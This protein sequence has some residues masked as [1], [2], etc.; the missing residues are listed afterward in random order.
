[1]NQKVSHVTLAQVPEPDTSVYASTSSP[2]AAASEQFADMQV[3]TLSGPLRSSNPVPVPTSPRPTRETPRYACVAQSGKAVPL[4]TMVQLL[5]PRTI[6]ACSKIIAQLDEERFL[7]RSIAWNYWGAGLHV[8]DILALEPEVYSTLPQLLLIQEME[9]MSRQMAHDRNYICEL[10][11]FDHSISEMAS[12]AREVFALV[13]TDPYRLA[14]RAALLRLKVRDGD[15]AWSQG[16]ASHMFNVDDHDLAVR[17][18]LRRIGHVANATLK[19]E[20]TV[21][22]EIVHVASYTPGVSRLARAIE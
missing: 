3:R 9:K 1:M 5:Y 18:L 22:A 16:A 11:V 4:P 8:E 20:E 12:I 14:R 15:D 6:V 2:L 7:S 10:E 21:L 19:D 13:Q 17:A